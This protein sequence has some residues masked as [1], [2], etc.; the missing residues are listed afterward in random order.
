MPLYISK[1]V[2]IAVAIQDDRIFFGDLDPACGSKHRL[3]AVLEGDSNFL[4]DDCRSG[5]DGDVVEDG[6][7]VVSEG[8]SL[9]CSHTDAVLHLVEDET[10]EGLALNV[11]GDN[12]KWALLLHGSLEELEDL[13]EVGHLVFGDE[14]EWLLELH[15][16]GLLVVD[17]VGRDEAPVELHALNELD[18]MLEGLA[19]ADSDH[20]G[21]ADLLDKV[22][23]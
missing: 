12:Q 16:L 17:E 13:V 1:C 3:I 23:Q 21:L 19:L 20:S 18:F 22:G 4:G 9:D 2:L 15:L 7:S 5:E 11:I 14:D 8:R 6:L 10:G